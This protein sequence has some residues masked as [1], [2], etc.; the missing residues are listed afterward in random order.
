MFNFKKIT[1]VASSALMI[2]STV[3]LAA[4]ANYPAPFVQN[5]V[6]DVAIV[7][8]QNAASSDTSAAVALSSDLSAAL[9][10][11]GGSSS[12]GATPTGGDSFQ[13]RKNSDE[14]NL[15]DTATGVMSS[16][17]NEEDLPEVLADGTYEN[18][19]NTEYE[20]EQKIALGGG[21]QLNYFKD[22][23]FNDDTPS[24]G[25]NLT[26]DQDVL[27]Y[28]LDFTTSAESDVSSGDL[29]D[30]ET[31]TFSM[32]GREY[33]ILDAK[34]NTGSNSAK[35]TLLDSAATAIARE[36][37]TTSI[38]IGSKTYQVQ[39]VFISTS[40][41]KL[42]V[43]GQV[44]TSLTAG[45]TYRLSDGTYVGIKEI[46]ARDVAGVLGQVE[47]SI[48]SGKLEIEHGQT[49]QLNDETVEGLTGWITKT[50]T[51][52]K[53]SLDKIVLQWR[54]D[55][56][57]F[58]GPDSSLVIPGFNN[59][60]ISMS[61]F[62]APKS[63]TTIVRGGGSTRVELA[64]TLKDGDVT[65]PLLYTDSEGNF[66]GIG[67]DA[68]NRLVT[69]NKTTEVLYNETSG[70]DMLVVSY[71]TTS[72]AESYILQLH[73]WAYPSGVPQVDFKNVVTG[74]D[75][76]TNKKVGETLDLG[77]LTLT[78]STINASSGSNRYVT[79][80][81]ST[82]ASFNTLY[83]KEGLKIAMPFAVANTSTNSNRNDGAIS[84]NTTDAN[85]YSAGHSYDTFVL[86]FTDENKDDDLGAGNKFNVTLDDNSDNEPH[87]ASFD[88]SR[89]TFADPVDSNTISA[90]TY[91]D[92]A[93]KV[94]REGASSDQRKVTITY[95]GSESYGKV[96]VSASGVTFSGGSD[97]GVLGSV[98]ITDSQASSASSKNL[99]VVGGSCVNTVAAQL[100]GASAP[101]CGADFTSRTG[102][103][104]SGQ[105]LVQSFA[106]P[107]SSSKVALLVAGYNA[108]DTQN[109]AQ[110]LRTTKPDTA[111]G[112]KYVGTTATSAQLVTA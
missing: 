107:L 80:N 85:M 87:A 42:S 65:I 25:I 18:D 26:S 110:Y 91:D 45:G 55:D 8:G 72:D 103:V 3:A 51:S 76:A 98:V 39:V 41:V 30:F 12:S 34:N 83:T 57:A 48:G 15:R 61:E 59:V 93:T 4:A 56:E 79:L 7:T 86:F 29:V 16:A 2:G 64:T 17:L 109:A 49:I 10:S 31:T 88:V 52:S 40:N 77:S 99:I 47:F 37:E 20:Y 94:M 90:Y 28:T 63:E 101:A 111:V 22:S 74:L 82:G 33:Y 36:G 9:A 70:D 50:E 95:A 1:S 96:F 44:T 78:I 43:D 71:N 67:K 84:F 23:D 69:S 75:V 112:K 24:I 5:G 73:N 58:I 62:Y 6:A 89:G 21:L 104:S 100:L 11:Q 35:L 66:T 102:G 108:E 46:L 68:N 97:G 81:G 13:I 54:T 53:V 38:T 19:E 92:V 106:S 60:M 14:F 105:F 32:L 27:N